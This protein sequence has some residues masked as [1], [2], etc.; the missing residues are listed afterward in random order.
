MLKK[1]LLLITILF[2]CV[3][4]WSQTIHLDFPHFANQEY[5]VSLLKGEKPDTISHGK[6][7]KLGKSAIVLPPAYKDY[8]GILRWS[9]LQGGGLAFALNGKENFTVRC[10]KAAPSDDN[11]VFINTPENEFMYRQYVRQSDIINKAMACRPLLQQY[12]TTSSIY[13]L[14]AAEHDRLE[15]EFATLQDNISRSPMYAARICEYS[16]FLSGTGSRLTLTEQ[17][18][19]AERRAFVM[20]R[21]DLKEL[22]HSG[23]WRDII[24]AHIASVARNDSLLL[25]DSRALLARAS[26]DK[27]MEESL[28]RGLHLFYNKYGKENLLVNLGIEELVSPGRLAP[29]LRLTNKH[30]RPINSLVVFYE[31]GCN[32]CDNEILQLRGNYPLLKEK[33]I[34]IISIAADRDEETYNNTAKDFPWSEQYC[35]YK[36]FAGE[37]FRNYELVGTPTFFLTDKDG[38]IIGR[39]ARLEEAF[40]N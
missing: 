12:D 4:L 6:L 28:L 14:V 21:L 3:T 18:A 34:E 40:K 9:L 23:F 10:S 35:D 22:Y 33:G 39:Y 38:I 15:R 19:E 29:M 27:E 11:I 25:A 37:N 36:G 31:S 17:E 1:L 30:I 2:A 5:V 24:D 13:R 16:D 32:S 7:D 8:K 26:T 20:E